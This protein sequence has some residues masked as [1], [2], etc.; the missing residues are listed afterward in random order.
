MFEIGFLLI[1]FF[2]VA[3]VVNRRAQQK[4]AAESQSKKN[5]SRPVP[6]GPFQQVVRQLQE[7]IEWAAGIAPD[8]A[9]KRVQAESAKAKESETAGSP[10]RN[11]GSSSRGLETP[12]A[13]QAFRGSMAAAEDALR[14]SEEGRPG[15]T[16]RASL[17]P[18]LKPST[19]AFPVI[20]PI[21]RS[22]LIQAVVMQEILARPGSARRPRRE[23]S[24][25]R[26]P[27]G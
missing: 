7:S 17:A 12:F 16:R 10:S 24:R 18:A 1:I 21:T 20:P 8:E 23:N 11:L 6:A 13:E 15:R 9:A 25:M 22:T 14:S 2:A 4:Q 26:T 27:Q 3:S 19:K 5:Q